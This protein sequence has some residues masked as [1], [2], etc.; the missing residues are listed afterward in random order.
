[1]RRSSKDIVEKMV[2]EVRQPPAISNSNG[3]SKGGRRVKAPSQSHQVESTA[4]TYISS[5][6]M[7]CQDSLEHG[8]K[9]SKAGYNSDAIF[10]SS[11]RHKNYS[12]RH[13]A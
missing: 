3:M 4:I 1:M 5:T 8:S 12:L 9:L 11:H 2:V 7:I 13:N 6:S 10:Q